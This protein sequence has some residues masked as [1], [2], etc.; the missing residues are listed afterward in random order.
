MEALLQLLQN[1][2]ACQTGEADDS[3]DVDVNGLIFGNVTDLLPVLAKTLKSGFV[4]AY[5]TIHKTM[6]KFIKTNKGYDDISQT[7]GVFGECFKYVP[8]LIQGYCEELLPSIIDAIELNDENINRNVA[9]TLGVFCAHGKDC[10]LA[11]YPKIMQ[12][13]KSIYD[14]A[15]TAET[16]D[17]AVA[18]IAKM[19]FTNAA[20][21]PLNLVVPTIMGV[22]PFQGDLKEN[23]TAVRFIIYFLETS[24]LLR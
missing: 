18:A 17:N 24:K 22:L 15:T 19:T 8:E 9:F 2:G 14:T 21:M 3:D 10:M 7:I 23:K 20:K 6:K 11:Y 16:K 1:R 4:P 13:M 5:K 12:A